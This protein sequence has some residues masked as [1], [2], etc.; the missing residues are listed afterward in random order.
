ML[1]LLLYHYQG[2]RFMKPPYDTN[3]SEKFTL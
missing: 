3:M 2:S 1:L